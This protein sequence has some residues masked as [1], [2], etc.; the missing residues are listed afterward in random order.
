MNFDSADIVRM[1]AKGTLFEVILHEMGHVLGFSGWFFSMHGLASGNNYTGTIALN[2]YRDLTGNQSWSS[3]PLEDGGGSGTAGGHWEED[4]FVTEL[5]TGYAEDFPPMPLSILTVSVLEDLGYV[6]NRAQADSFSLPQVSGL[7]SNIQ[8][9]SYSSS[10]ISGLSSNIQANSESGIQTKNSI[11]TLTSSRLVVPDFNGSVFTY[12]DEKPLILDG[13]TIIQKLEGAVTSSSENIV[14]FVETTTGFNYLVKLEGN[15]EK[16]SP[17]TSHNI[18]GT[19]SKI[20]FMIGVSP[21]PTILEYEDM[22]DVQDVLNNWHNNFLENNNNI[23][24]ISLSA[25]DDYVDAGAGDDVIDLGDGDDTLIGGDGNDILQGGQGNDKLY[26]E[27]G[28]DNLTGGSGDDL[29][30]G[31]AGIDTSTYSGGLSD[32]T[33]TKVADNWV[34]TR[35]DDSDTLVNIERLNFADANVALDLNGNAGKTAKL[36]GLLLGAEAVSNKEYIGVG[37]SLLD[38]GMT[39]E[40]L[41]QAALDVVL[42]ANASSLSV[43]ELIWNNLIGPPTQ[44]D[45]ISQYSALIDNGTYTPAGLA[46]VAAD[47]SMNTTNIDLVGLSQTGL[48]FIP[49]G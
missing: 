36:L 22:V 17:A 48:E 34:I 41:M 31:G 21:S 13:E 26:G 18:K 30:Y 39:Y 5:M 20:S 37:L 40:E 9:N 23:A 8:T 49:Y 32:F 29:L 12:D 27:A 4:I 44:A 42:G 43:V 47:H 19:V 11:D 10:Q 2:A 14:F 38:G 25:T 45:N 46:I 15:F 6:V 28:N 7:S 1:E 35:S 3:V 24:V 33:L 16:N